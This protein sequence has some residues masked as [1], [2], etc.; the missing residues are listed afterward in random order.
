MTNK[1]AT[2]ARRCKRMGGALRNLPLFLL[3]GIVSVSVEVFAWGSILTENVATVSILGWDVRLAYAEI[4][5]STAFSLAALVLAAAAAAQKAD[6]RPDQRRRAGAAQFLAIV[7][8]IAPVYYAGNCLAY[9]RQ[10]ADWSEYSG[11]EAEAADRNLA[12][13]NTVDSLVRLQATANMHRGIRPER[14]EFDPLATAWIAL[15]LGCNMLAVR[16][17]WRARPESPAEAKSRLA[18]LRVAKAKH[19]RE[20]NA[21]ERDESNVAR[22]FFRKA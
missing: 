21:R 16:L 1:L 12:A 3:C 15:L 2:F 5:M 18:M 11:S 13:S 8:L 7:V 4:G 20:R 17:G 10:L 9:Q 22:P 14:A 6:P 19:T